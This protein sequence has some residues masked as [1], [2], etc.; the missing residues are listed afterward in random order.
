MLARKA[1]QKDKKVIIRDKE[2]KIS[3]VIDATRHLIET[4]GYDKVTI[5]DIAEVADVS[6]GTIYRYFPGG[7]FD[8]IIK[9]FGGQTLGYLLM[10]QHPDD[11]DYA[12]FPGYMRELIV[13]YR[14]IARENRALMKALI[15]ASLSEGELLEG[16]RNVDVNDMTAIAELF[17]RFEGVDIT[18]RDPA[19]L[20]LEWGY[21]GKR[22]P[23]LQYDVPDPV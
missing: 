22:Y 9:G 2:A 13:K 1:I 8:I 4:M 20:L 15:A 3:A 16:V 21:D 12:D 17:G 5:Q 23:A 19:E 11:L 10:P 6:V 18:G 14:D 7:K